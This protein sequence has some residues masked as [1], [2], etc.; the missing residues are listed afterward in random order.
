MF[1]AGRLPLDRHF[2]GRAK[3]NEKG[4]DLLRETYRYFGKGL[5]VG[6]SFV[7]SAEHGGQEVVFRSERA[8][9][10]SVDQTDFT[11]SMLA[12]ADVEYVK[13]GNDIFIVGNAAMEFANVSYQNVRRPLRNGL[14]SPSESEA[15]P[16]I[17]MIVSRMILAARQSGESLYYSVPG[18]PLDTE[19]NLGYHKKTLQSMIQKLGYNAKPINEGLAVV[20]AELGGDEHFTGIGMSFGGGMVNVCF[21]YRSLPLLMFSITRSG[22]WI[23]ERAAMAVGENASYVCSIKEKGLDLTQSDGLSK[24]PSALGIAYDE[25]IHSVAATLTK[26]VGKMMNIPRLAEPLPVV[27]SG[28]TA[29]PRGFTERFKQA[30]RSENFPLEIARVKLAEDPFGSVARGAMIAAQAGAGVQDG[31]EASSTATDAK[32][33]EAESEGAV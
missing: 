5:D 17:E 25:L 18:E 11:E 16:M 13:S 8:A 29:T 24:I 21:A 28:G 7:R 26:Q 19:V 23:D 9:F 32:T 20:F 31:S 10:V 33:P 27:L 22:D 4:V 2:R 30:L 14:I 15:L 3:T 1:L 6:T 12:M